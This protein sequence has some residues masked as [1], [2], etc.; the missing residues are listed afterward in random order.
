MASTLVLG[1]TG[2]TGSHIL[3]TLLLLPS[4]QVSSIT[5]ISRRPPPQT[6]NAA[7]SPASPK[8]ITHVEKDTTKWESLVAASS[9]SSQGESSAPP[10]ILFSALATTRA[11][12]GGFDKQ[13]V[14]EHDL[15]ITLA[16]AARSHATAPTS[17]Y[18]LISS[19]SASVDARFP[20]VRMKG[21]IERD[22]LA[23]DFAHTVIL[24]PGLIGG[25]REESRPAEAAIRYVADSLG[26]VSG[27]KLKD[28]W[29]QDADVIGRAAVRAGLRAQKG[30]L[31]GKTT[32]L[33]GKEIMELG[34]HPLTE[35]EKQG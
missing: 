10:Q 34:K 21:E 26:W 6:A 35:E 19:S 14:L 31:T 3:S 5:T 7:S 28:F 24:R 29:A 30:E 1:S 25:Q 13:Y 12:A 15:N 4:S 33:Y 9:D 22:I 20:Y 2:M 32:M 27:G 18:V 17:T 11:A 16:K 8:V 23:L